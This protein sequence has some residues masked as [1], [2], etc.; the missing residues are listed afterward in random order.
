MS[1][2]TINLKTNNLKKMKVAEGLKELELILKDKSPRYSKT[3]HDK[4][5]GIISVKEVKKY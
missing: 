2:I 1:K 5:L 3:S 4:D